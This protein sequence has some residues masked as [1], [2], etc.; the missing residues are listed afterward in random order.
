MMIVRMK[1]LFRLFKVYV[2]NLL[3]SKIHTCCKHAYRDG[4]LD[5]VVL[6]HLGVEDGNTVIAKDIRFGFALA[7]LSP[8]F[9]LVFNH[10]IWCICI[11]LLAFVSYKIHDS[12]RLSD[13]VGCIYNG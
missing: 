10:T 3:S 6:R 7:L 12:L 11:L 9:L 1:P 8:I 5:E 4:W 13:L 2:R